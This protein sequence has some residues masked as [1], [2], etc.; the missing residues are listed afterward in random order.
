MMTMHQSDVFK[1]N[2]GA[3]FVALY[4]TQFNRSFRM[5]GESTVGP[6]VVARRTEIT[7]AVDSEGRFLRG[8]D[9]TQLKLNSSLLQPCGR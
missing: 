8:I 2:D 6:K 5:F 7:A 9:S 1:R 4:R 3:E